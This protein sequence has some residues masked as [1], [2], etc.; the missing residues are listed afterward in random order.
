MVIEDVL[1]LINQAAVAKWTQLH[2]PAQ[3]L[4]TIPEEITQLN[5]L[6]YLDLSRNK[7]TKIPDTIAQLKNI[8]GL[9]L[10]YN[11]ISE[12]PEEIAH[13]ENL[14]VLELRFN[15][16]TRF[17]DICS[18]LKN[19]KKL[20]LSH[21]RIIKFPDVL[22][23][24][25]TLKVLNLCSNGIIEIPPEIADFRKLILLDL[26]GNYIKVIPEKIVSSPKLEDLILSS[27]QY[28]SSKSTIVDNGTHVILSNPVEIPP[29]EIAFG[30]IQA[31]RNYYKQLAEQGI[32]HL[33]AAKLLIVGEAGAGKTTLANKIQNPNYSLDT[34]T[35]HG[36]DIYPWT[37]PY[38]KNNNFQV[39]IWDFGGQEIYHSTHQFFLTQRSLYILVTDERKEDTDFDYWLNIVE[40]LAPDSPIIVVQNERD[41]RTRKIDTRGLKGRFENLE[42]MIITD[43]KTGRNLAEVIK[44]ICF[45]LGNLPHIGDQLPKIWVKI[46]KFLQNNRRNFVS[47][48]LFLSLCKKAGFKTLEDSLQLSHY[49]HDLGTILHFQDDPLLKK[50]VILN[51][52]WGTTAVYQILDNKKVKD[53]FGIFS[54]NDLREIW[55]DPEYQQM[56]DELLQLMLKFKLCYQLPQQPDTFLAPELLNPELPEYDWQSNANLIVHYEYEFM[57]KGILTT[58]IVEMHQYL[59][60]QDLVWRNGMI[61]QDHDTEAEVIETYSKR[62]IRIRAH[63][64]HKRDLVTKITYEIGKIHSTFPGIRVKK[65]IP[66]NCR[67]TCYSSSEPHF[68]DERI[69]KQYMADSQSYIQC[70]KSYEMV[71]VWSLLDDVAS[72]SMANT[73]AKNIPREFY[74]DYKDLAT[75]SVSCPTQVHNGDNIDQRNS[76]IGVGVNEGNIGGQSKVIGKHTADDFS[77][78]MAS[79]QIMC[80]YIDAF[81]NETQADLDDEID[82]F[83]AELINQ[84]EKSNTRKL[85][86][87]LKA[88]ALAIPP[89]PSP[90]AEITYFAEIIMNLA[91]KIDPSQLKTVKNILQQ[92]LPIDD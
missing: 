8:Q 48:T 59:K 28:S 63:G 46:R 45:Q 91:E 39:N 25:E 19:L 1:R 77:E 50:T 6:Q 47:S 31:I 44:E 17:P 40:L 57:P 60:S 36:I 41:G 42:A 79:L 16:I 54:R 14:R 7:I 23:Q 73:N 5:S 75:R 30:G 86:R 35:T 67:K 64:S 24:L 13:L 26:S 3:N 58:L 82:D 76:N 33:Y 15:R 90:T 83:E 78:I 72:I 55:Q 71:N 49:L 27:D 87:R 53:N 88:I 70:N 81:P 52:E 61:L 85:M 20:D 4:T 22:T 74:E 80:G 11:E 69:L 68:Y 43:L 51:P 32:D 12:I 18:Q 84:K 62:E 56:T 2:L 38:D 9:K 66:C 29:P 34:T 37:F 21:N 89:T 92:V 65:L 10:S